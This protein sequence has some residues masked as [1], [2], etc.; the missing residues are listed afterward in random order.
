[1][2]RKNRTIR[3]SAIRT[4]VASSDC[5]AGACRAMWSRGD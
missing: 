2:S 4:L 1:V 5:E 3:R